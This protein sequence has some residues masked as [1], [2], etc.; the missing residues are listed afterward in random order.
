MGVY[1]QAI[2]AVPVRVAGAPGL[3]ADVVLR[4]D[5]PGG[6]QQREAPGD[7]FIG[8]HVLGEREV[9]LAAREGFGVHGRCAPGRLCVAGPLQGALLIQALVTDGAEARRQRGDFVHDL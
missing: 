5:A 9:A 2:F 7:L 6:Q 1:L 4:Q 8:G 3:R